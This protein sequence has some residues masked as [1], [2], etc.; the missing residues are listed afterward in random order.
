MNKDIRN[1]LGYCFGRWDRLSQIGILVGN[2]KYILVTL[3]YF[4][5][6][7]H[8]IH[9]DEVDWSS[10]WEELQCMPIEVLE[11]VAFAAWECTYDVADVFCHVQ[12]VKYVT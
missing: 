8:N 10:F 3:C 12:P 7:S 5:R 11:F 9:C 1:V 4:K 6:R 2:D